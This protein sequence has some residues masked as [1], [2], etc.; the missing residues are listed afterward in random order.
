MR[1][2]VVAAIVLIACIVLIGIAV[3][4]IM[5][6]PQS[7][8]A[9]PEPI[10]IGIPPTADSS[11]LVYIAAEQGFFADNGLNVTLKDYDVGLRAVDGMLRNE[12]DIAVATE[13]VIVSKAFDRGNICGIAT[14]AKYEDKFIIGR[15]DRGIE[16]WDDLIGKRIGCDRGTISEFFLGRYLELHDI[17]T[18]D[19]DIVDIKRPR[20][21]EAIGNG[22]VD[23]IIVWGPEVGEI[24]GRLGAN[25]VSLPAQSGQRGYWIAICRSD[26]AASHPGLVERFL[27]SL[28]QAEDYTIYHPAEARAIMKEWLNADDAYIDT[29][30]SST[31]FSLSLDAS[32]VTAMEDEARWMIS[33]NLTGERTVP[34]F[35]D[36]ICAGSLM[37]VKPESVNIIM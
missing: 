4:Y 30:W 10:T 1:K 29:I 31:Q 6:A 5:F 16:S 36:Y 35:G 17:D 26:W 12:N 23:A 9:A 37:E 8:A 27:R 18:G 20:F 14:V 28:D 33:N 7:P 21:V 2:P 32:L 34:D 22:T 11:G 13:F 24:T 15:R 3:W 19:V 25:A